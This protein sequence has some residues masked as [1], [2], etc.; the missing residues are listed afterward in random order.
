MKWLSGLVFLVVCGCLVVLVFSAAGGGS[1]A[2]TGRIVFAT[3]HY[4]GPRGFT[5]CGRG[6]IAVVDPDG[7]GLR[8]LTHAGAA[9]KVSEYSPRWSPDRHQIAYLRPNVRSG[10]RAAG[11]QIWLMSADGTHQRALTHLRSSRLV[12]SD[13]WGPALDWA[14]NGRQ[15]VFTDTTNLYLANVRTGAV[16]RLLRAAGFVGWPAWSPNGRWIAF[17]LYR[18]RGDPATQGSLGQIFLLSTST[19]RL[20][21]VTHFPTGYR[22]GNPAWSPDSSRIAFSYATTPATSVNFNVGIGVINLDGTHFQSLNAPGFEPSWSPDGNWIVFS[23]SNGHHVGHP[24]YGPVNLE[25]MKSD[26]TGLHQI[27]HVPDHTWKDSQPDW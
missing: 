11:P 1:S 16:T 17:A 26:G 19:H 22:P 20:Q 13:V 4:C 24:Y 15:I 12:I 8:F 14:P 5:N 23:A 2:G 6:D 3:N 18:P 7:S 25:V 21:Q 27:T 9:K 10:P